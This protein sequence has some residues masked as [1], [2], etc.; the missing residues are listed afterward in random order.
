[1]QITLPG[2]YI[3]A[4]TGEL[5]TESEKDWL[6]KLEKKPI[7]EK[8]KKKKQSPSKKSKEETVIVSPVKTKTLQF[9]QDNI[10]DFAWFA[11]K[12]FIVRGDTLR[13]PSG[14]I[15]N[16]HAYYYANNLKNVPLMIFGSSIATAAFPRLTEHAASGNR[17]KLTEDLVVN[18]RLSPRSARR[19]MRVAGAAR[20]LLFRHVARFARAARGSR[21]CQPLTSPRRRAKAAPS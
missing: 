14:K 6:K 18:A 11:D 2:D 8:T 3:V 4:A 10:H 19:L 1:M 15:I 17:Q 5:Q 21:M 20:R 12:E 7:P 9:K 16:A 13:L